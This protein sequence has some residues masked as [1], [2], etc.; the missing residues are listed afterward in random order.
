VCVDELV[1]TELSIANESSLSDTVVSIPVPPVNVNVWPVVNVSFDPLS[2]A[3]VNEPDGTAAKL[4]LPEPSVVKNCP[5]LK[6]PGR[7][8]VISEATLLG[9]FKAT[10]CAPLLVPS[11]NL[12]VPPTVVELPTLSVS[13]ALFESVIRADEAVSVPGVW[14]NLLVKYTAIL[15]HLN[16]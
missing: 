11:L 7:V 14:L 6:L 10:K 16:V 13:I 1:K 15:R 5:L 3:N 12:I 8:Y 9:A 2:A 4:K